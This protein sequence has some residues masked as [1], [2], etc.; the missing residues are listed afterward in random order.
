MAL[1]DEQ[2][3]HLSYLSSGRAIMMM[4]GLSKAVQVQIE[5]T[6]ENDTERP[7]LEDSILRDR[8]IDYYSDVYMKGILPGLERLNEKPDHKLVELYLDYLQ[9][10]SQ[11]VKEYY[12][13]IH[14]KIISDAFIVE[15]KT[16]IDLFD[17]K[18]IALILCCHCHRK[19]YLITK[20]EIYEY[21]EKLL[22]NISETG[23]SYSIKDYE[24][25]LVLDMTLEEGGY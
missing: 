2:K 18:T 5:K 21:V 22:K 11:I 23:V 24:P 6:K 9:P 25:Y 13:C 3:E 15:I 14:K 10:N 17:L 19:D 16:L 7:P 1:K 4:P 8:I 12:R 20:P